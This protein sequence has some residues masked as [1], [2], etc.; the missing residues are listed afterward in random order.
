LELVKSMEDKDE[1][2]AML[3]AM[4]HFAIHVTQKKSLAHVLIV[5]N[6][7]NAVESVRKLA[8]S[9]GGGRVEGIRIGDIRPVA[10]KAILKN[11]LAGLK[12]ITDDDLEFVIQQVGGRLNDLETF[13]Q[14]VVAGI[15]PKE[16]VNQ[17]IHSLINEIRAE[18]FGLTKGKGLP[19]KKGEGHA[20]SNEGA[21]SEAKHTPKWTQ[22]E[23]WR[24]IRL[25]S[26][27]EAVS[28]DEL[29]FNIFN[30][31]IAALNA[32]LNTNLL[33]AVDASVTAYS[34]L[35]RTA[36][37]VM[38]HDPTISIGMDIVVAKAELQEET[39]RLLKIE[40]E[41]LKLHTLSP[42]GLL[43]R[44]SIAIAERKASLEGK[45]RESSTRITK[46]DVSLKELQTEAALRTASVVANKQ[47]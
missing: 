29:L 24:T 41:L 40:D 47:T 32:L 21:K 1:A 4:T 11:G 37:Q 31:N 13:M 36:F 27:H 43:A 10:A 18:G 30:G 22:A 38:A 6:D 33:L 16:S 15:K 34:P 8:S 9:R 42:T 45:M 19:K 35:Y 2:H 3:D 14:K 20:E 28:Y 7:Q 26:E 17:M 46:L 5:S 44:D 12:D 25:L 39:A 23:L